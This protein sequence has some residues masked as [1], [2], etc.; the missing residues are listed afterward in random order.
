M[1]NN[2]CACGLHDDDHGHEHEN[3]GREVP[4]WIP[5]TLLGISAV[6]LVVMFF[7]PENGTAALILGIVASLLAGGKLFWRSIRALLKLRLDEG[8]MMVVAVP[9]C[10][11]LGDYREAVAIAL[12]FALGQQLEEIASERSRKAI[13]ALSDLRPDQ[14]H[15]SKDGVIT[16][17]VPAEDVQIGEEITVQPFERVPLDGVVLAGSSSVDTSSMTGESAAR[18]VEPGDALLSGFVNGSGRLTMQTTELAKDSAASRLIDLAEHAATQKGSSERFLQRFAKIYTPTVM[19]LGLLLAVVPS[20][21]TGDWAVWVPRGLLFLVSACP[22]AIVLSVPLGFFAAIGGSAKRGVLVKGGR[23]VELLA[24]AEIAVFDKTGTLTTDQ[25]RITEIFAAEG[26]TQDDVLRTAAIAEQSS[27][28]PFA[29]AIL[30]AAPESEET[31]LDQLEELPGGGIA[32]VADGKEILCGSRRM[33]EARG[34]DCS[35]LPPAQV[36]VSVD[37]RALGSIRCESALHEDAPEAIAQ[38]RALGVKKCVLLT[39]DEPVAAQHAADQ[40]GLDE[41]HAALLPEDKLTHLAQLQQNGSVFYVGDGVNDAP[42]LAQADVGVAMGFGA[43]AAAEAADAVIMGSSLKPLAHARALFQ[44]TLR[45]T[46]A[47]IVFSLAVKAVVIAI[48]LL[49]P[50]T[51]VWLAVVADVGVMVLAVANAARLL[52]K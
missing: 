10:F 52:K 39:G 51:P 3:G 48:G 7:L 21:I 16:A 25:F 43:Q 6:C 9:A 44:K 28:H 36:L 31:P 5:W 12:F 38:L 33:L 13:T 32:A 50:V 22:C 46:R 27:A 30:A 40:C 29:K 8:I 35:A 45:I 42:V 18:E 2:N 11:A 26:A 23:Y 15:R 24:K 19:L 37:G 4:A 34:V 17:T 49:M 20:L 41:V 14:A 1:A 47:N